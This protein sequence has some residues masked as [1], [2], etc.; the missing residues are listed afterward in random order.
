LEGISF[1]PAPTPIRRRHIPSIDLSEKDSSNLAKFIQ[2]LNKISF[3]PIFI[4]T[5]IA[6]GLIASIVIN[7]DNWISIVINQSLLGFIGLLI[8]IYDRAYI[9]PKVKERKYNE[10]LLDSFCWGILGCII[11]GVGII[12]LFK[13]ILIFI[14]VITDKKNKNLKA[15]DYGLLA[16]NSINYFS[17]K[18]GY[19][20]ILMGIY[21]AFSDRFNIFSGTLIP[22]SLP[23]FPFIPPLLITFSIL[24]L[25]SFIALLIDKKLRNDIKI[26]QRFTIRDLIKVIIIGILG[27]LFYAAGI[28]ILLKAV[29]IFLLIVGKPS[30]KVEIIPIQEEPDTYQDVQK[31][32]EPPILIEPVEKEEQIEL[33]KEE[34]PTPDV[35]KEEIV[36]EQAE[37]VKEEVRQIEELAEIPIR[38]EKERKEE[39]FEL[40]LHDSLLPV[41]DEKD[42]KLVKQYFAKIF[43]VLSKE[44]RQQINDLKIPK[45]ERRELLEE[46]AFLTFEE[47]VKYIETIVELY[48]EIP[49]KLI[50]RIRKL[51]NVKPEHYDK[52]IDQLKYMDTQE[53]IKFIQFL[54]ENA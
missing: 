38:E 10:V 9:A 13:G 45:K 44:V 22:L 24:L 6:F 34:I 26:K 7:W 49:K 15:Y 48:K 37:I 12:L 11:H 1:K 25:I 54:E 5:F 47:Q 39:E 2:F 43:A 36:I 27:T 29:L 23:G 50:E 14:Y 4:Y 21:A 31:R 53:Q 35:P 18:T 20:I 46:L 51:P 52:I 19:V 42:K 17:S 3:I 30:D 8:V 33:V 40:R 41:K 16:K 32:E 28:F